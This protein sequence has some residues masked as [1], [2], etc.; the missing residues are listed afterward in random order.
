MAVEVCPRGKD[1]GSGPW[2]A[3]CGGVSRWRPQGAERPGQDLTVT[4]SLTT[5]AV[6]E[7]TEGSA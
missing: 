1:G 7:G 2:A 3:A 4:R 5:S 6:A